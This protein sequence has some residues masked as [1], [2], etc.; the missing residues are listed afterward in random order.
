M[1]PYEQA[2]KKAQQKAIRT[3]KAVIYTDPRPTAKG[4]YTCNAC[5]LAA[6]RGTPLP[7]NHKNCRCQVVQKPENY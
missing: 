1:N 7:P 4:N 5:K 2:M 3:K 6:R